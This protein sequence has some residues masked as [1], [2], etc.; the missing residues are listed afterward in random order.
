MRGKE[1]RP[2]SI[3]VWNARGLMVKKG[4]KQLQL[5]LI[6]AERR[7]RVIAITESHLDDS[8]ED[9][10]ID[11][12]G[13]KIIRQDRDLRKSAKKKGGGVIVYVQDGIEVDCVYKV[14]EEDLELVAFDMPGG[15]RYAIAYRRPGNG[16]TEDALDA[17]ETAFAGRKKR[18]LA[19]DLNMNMRAKTP[20]PRRLN[21]QLGN[22]LKMEQK[23]GFITRHRG[24]RGSVIDHVWTNMNC[25]CRPDNELDGASDHR[26][27]RV[28]HD[29]DGKVE[30]EKPRA[31]LKKYWDEA[32]VSRMV[33]VIKEEMGGIGE[34]GTGS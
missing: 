34:S 11:I 3:I 8:F 2:P 23:V 24:K 9:G 17:I 21:T 5:A 26:A 13:Y 7:P 32:P 1:D 6:A 19:G 16:I 20:V 15:I 30:P 12:P 33:Q 18:L 31:V 22:E 10:E 27:I 4:H 29:E 28:Y 25:I 14:A